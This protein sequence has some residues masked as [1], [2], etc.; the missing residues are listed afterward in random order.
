MHGDLQ[1]I[2][3]NV[4]EDIDGLTMLPE[5]T[6]FTKVTKKSTTIIDVETD[7]LF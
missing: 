2:M 5:T 4:L 3:G 1:S 6:T 7:T